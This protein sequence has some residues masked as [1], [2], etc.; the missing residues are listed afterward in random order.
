MVV[1]LNYVGYNSGLLFFN[2]R[3]E[4]LT[5]ETLLQNAITNL[6]ETLKKKD[7]L[8]KGQTTYG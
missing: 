7:T 5:I 4:T 6:N 2:R 8:Y 1:N 3:I